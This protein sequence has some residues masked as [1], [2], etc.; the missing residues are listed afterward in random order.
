MYARFWV[1]PEDAQINPRKRG[2]SLTASSSA[3]PRNVLSVLGFNVI[4]CPRK[5]LSFSHSCFYT[6]FSKLLS[7]GPCNNPKSRGVYERKSVDPSR[8]VLASV[9]PR[10]GKWRSMSKAF[11]EWPQRGWRSTPLFAFNFLR[12]AHMSDGVVAVPFQN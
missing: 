5:R 3:L 9:D 12:R 10:V 6:G 1:T 7:N 2:G 8:S 11:S 4:R